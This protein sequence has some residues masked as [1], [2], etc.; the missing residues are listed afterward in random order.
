MKRLVAYPIACL[1]ILVT[2]SGAFA[3]Y[4]NPCAGDIAKFC[5]NV[6]PGKG[7]IADC[8]SQNEAKLSPECRSLHLE[9]LAEVLRQTHQ[10][11]ETDILKFC[12]SEQMQ[13]GVQLMKCMWGFQSSLSPEC[14][15]NLL[16]ALQMM[17]Y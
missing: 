9:D 4:V 8:L 17:R 5:S 12:P 10:A 7:Y 14:N 2:V 11:C 3:E 16:K 1:V 6:Q 15:K 13:S